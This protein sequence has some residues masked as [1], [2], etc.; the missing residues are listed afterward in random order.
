MVEGREGCN[1]PAMIVATPPQ[2][3]RPYLPR[4]LPRCDEIMQPRRE[5]RRATAK[6]W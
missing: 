6:G 3:P 5:G 1:S 4:D 2:R